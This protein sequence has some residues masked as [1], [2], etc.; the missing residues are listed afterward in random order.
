MIVIY[1]FILF[2][3]DNERKKK[4]INLEEK[5]NQ[6]ALIIFDVNIRIIR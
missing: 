5:N 2:I 6:E 3:F 4:L 1:T